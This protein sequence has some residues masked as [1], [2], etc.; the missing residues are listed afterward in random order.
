MVRSICHVRLLYPNRLISIHTFTV[1]TLSILEFSPNRQDCEAS[2]G[3]YAS[4]QY[5]WSWVYCGGWESSVICKRLVVGWRVFFFCWYVVQASVVPVILF[6]KI[7]FV[8]VI[9]ILGSILDCF[10][11]FL[12]VCRPSKQGYL[13]Y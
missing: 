8:S 13:F 7:A 12:M 1:S 3:C 10:F 5:R 2:G 11:F 9:L 6:T 4:F